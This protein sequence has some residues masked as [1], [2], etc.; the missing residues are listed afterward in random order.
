[1]KDLKIEIFKTGHD[2]NPETAATI[3]FSSLHI[4]VPLLPRKIRAVLDKEGI[5]I[6]QCKELVKEKA[7]KGTIIE[8]ENPNEKMVISVQ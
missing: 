3:P 4:A 7:L 6:N 8:I 2:V 5:D 1:M